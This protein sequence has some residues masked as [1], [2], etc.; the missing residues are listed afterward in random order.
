M[1]QETDQRLL[2]ALSGMQ[3]SGP[4]NLSRYVEAPN[5]DFEKLSEA[6]VRKVIQ[7]LVRADEACQS[8]DLFASLLRKWDN[9]KDNEDG[10]WAK[11]TPRNTVERR[12]LIHGLLGLSGELAAQVDGKV[13]FLR[14]EEPL[15]ITKNPGAWTR[16]V[17]ANG[18][19]YY[20]NLYQKYLR[21]K[22]GLGDEAIL[23]LDNSIK[24][25]LGCLSQPDSPAAYSS[26]GLVVGYVQSG[27]TSNFTG[28]IARAADAGYRLIIILAGTWNILRNQTQRRIDKELLGQQLVEH[29][30][31]YSPKPND[32]D[33]F[34]L[35]EFHPRERG[36]FSWDRVTGPA[37]D[38]SRM[39]PATNNLDYVKFEEG[40]EIFHLENLKKMNVKLLVIK[41]HSKIITNLAKDL[42][43]TNKLILNVPAIVIDDES[44]QAGLNT[45]KPELSKEEELERTKTNGAIVKLLEKLPR[46]QYIGYTATPYANAL[47]NPDD[48]ADLFP[49]DFIISLHRPAGYMGISDFFDPERTYDDLDPNDFSQNEVAFIRRVTSTVAADDADLEKA[50]LLFVLSGALKLFR[51][52]RHKGCVKTD[53]HTMLVHTSS[54]KKD[55]EKMARRIAGLWHS[56]G[57][58]S[59]GGLERLRRLWEQD[60]LP[61]TRHHGEGLP[62]PREFGELEPFLGQAITKLTL[63]AS[64][65]LILNSDEK[66]APDFNAAPVWKIIVGGNKLSRGYTVEGLTISY[67]RRVTKTADTLMQM[68]RW[69][70]FREG[71]RDLVRVFVG[72]Q[73]GKRNP[74]NLVESFKATCLM[75]ERFRDEIKRY[76]KEEGRGRITPRD[77]PPLIEITGDLAPTAKNK[78]FN[79]EITRKNFG[80]Q[81]SQ[82]T[83]VAATEPGIRH[84]QQLLGRLLSKS[85]QVLNNEVLGGTRSDGKTD[86]IPC[87]GFEAAQ[88][89]VI[90]FLEGYRWVEGKFADGK[91]P[92]S[93]QLQ[94]EF[95]RTEKH[96]IDSWLVLLPQ[97]VKGESHGPTFPILKG[98][99]TNVRE[100]NWVE[101]GEGAKR[102][103]QVG[104]PAHRRLA[105]WMCKIK[106]TKGCYLEQPL[107]KEQKNRQN[108]RTGIFLAYAVRP[109]DAKGS[110]VIGFEMLYPENN[111]PKTIGFSVRDPRKADDIIISA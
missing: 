50:L 2:A 29:D 100:R 46:A 61:V 24:E 38:Y 79:A 53:H 110:A 97:T 74:V 47:V 80:G 108:P 76:V 57:M 60:I 3:R 85:L 87:H 58:N 84:N 28:L 102:L 30:E 35:H 8:A 42:G 105:K 49:K 103:Q 94:I 82:P 23:N 6:E 20:W 93:I 21:E 5:P 109:S 99:A 78:M 91:R 101:E 98:L 75:E 70:G 1:N 88:K 59:P 11:K 63:G 106:T 44:D 7:D 92:S 86:R 45:A 36:V 69:F 37:R 90:D 40:K 54:A 10:G 111:L 65:T 39:G 15:I 107:T 43:R 14:L 96:G 62:M 52:D 48:E 17:P 34:L 56:L 13:P 83:L 67:Y 25:I 12:A 4:K 16:P 68:G 22:K 19:S 77:I 26:R 33:K 55:H 95:L 18:D 31:A 64:H 51:N 66:D 104:E 73:E 9:T 41:K 27:K 72:V 81:W 89:D 32:W 71:Y